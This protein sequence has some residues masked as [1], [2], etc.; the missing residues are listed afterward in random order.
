MVA[1]YKRQ[2]QTLGSICTCYHLRD[3]SKQIWLWASNCAS[4]QFTYADG[5]PLQLFCCIPHLPVPCLAS[6][7]PPCASW[8]QASC[9]QECQGQ[10]V[11]LHL[12]V[13]MIIVESSPSQYAQTI[14][15]AR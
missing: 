8:S 5:G 13:P 10:W 7:L 12:L 3:P 1:C 15:E 11:Q 6:G 9:S 14:N 4:C 2:Q